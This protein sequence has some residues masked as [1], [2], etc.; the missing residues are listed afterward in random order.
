M[1]FIERLLYLLGL[2]KNPSPRYYEIDEGLQISLRTLADN[3]RR[4]EQELLPDLLA[5]GLD[6]YQSVDRFWWKWKSLSIR[7]QQVTALICLNLTNKEIAIRLSISPQTV[8]THVSHVLAKF[9]V[10]GRDE[11]RHTLVD[12]DFSAY[13]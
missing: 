6:K 8:K 3:E 7:E 13:Q 10:K 1:S 11:L 9:E 12:W 2:S 5:A 4:S